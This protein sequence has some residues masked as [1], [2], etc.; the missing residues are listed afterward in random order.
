MYGDMK[1]IP[2]TRE[3]VLAA[4]DKT[5]EALSR[6]SVAKAKIEALPDE[7]PDIQTLQAEIDAFRIQHAE[8]KRRRESE[9]S[10]AQ[11][12]A[13]VISDAFAE[14]ERAEKALDAAKKAQDRAES[15]LVV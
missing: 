9:F 15:R 7:L 14:R 10:A 12:L 11:R 4:W 2:T 1:K 13:K 6:L 3:Q 5:K 8:E